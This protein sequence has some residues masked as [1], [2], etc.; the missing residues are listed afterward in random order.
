[1]TS[2]LQEVH[3]SELYVVD[4][5]GRRWSL[6]LFSP[7]HSMSEYSDKLETVADHLSPSLQE[8][9]WNFHRVEFPRCP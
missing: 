1:M 4:G 2:N 8:K 6:K 7:T 9:V 5:K 3:A